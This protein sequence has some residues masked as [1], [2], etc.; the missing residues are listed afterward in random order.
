MEV[1]AETQKVK[2]IVSLLGTRI[3]N[4]LGTRFWLLAG[5]APISVLSHYNGAGLDLDWE[6]RLR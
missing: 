5:F 1:G 3:R 6:I 2:N 4:L